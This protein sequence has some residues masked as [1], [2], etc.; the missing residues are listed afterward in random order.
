VTGADIWEPL[1]ALLIWPESLAGDRSPAAVGLS[2]SAQQSNPIGSLLLDIFMV[3]NTG[4]P[5]GC[6]P[7]IWL[8]A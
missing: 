2:V 1:L 5:S 7:E 4:K 3:F 6:L 8:R